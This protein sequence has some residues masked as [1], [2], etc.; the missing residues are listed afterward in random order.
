MTTDWGL[1]TR[2]L[3]KH[4]AAVTRAT[5]KQDW[6]GVKAACKAAFADFDQHGWPDNWA[7]FQRAAD[8][9]ELKQYMA[10]RGL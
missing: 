8:D 7:H 4:K 9:A 6:E 3:R 5:N 10:R 2:L 1:V